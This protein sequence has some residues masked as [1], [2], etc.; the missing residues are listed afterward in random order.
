MKLITL[1]VAGMFAALVAAQAAS[2][3][4]KSGDVAGTDEAQITQSLEAA[5][6][7]EVEV[8][9][10]AEDNNIEVD[11]MLDGVEVEFEVSSKTGEV[12]SVDEDS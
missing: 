9:I 3:A 12:I 11:A 7:T 1:T 2:A 8:E 10:E 6:Y 4:M 5:G